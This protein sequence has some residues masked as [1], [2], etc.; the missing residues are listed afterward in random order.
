MCM[1]IC[2]YMLHIRV[3]CTCTRTIYIIG[4]WLHVSSEAFIRRPLW[5]AQS[6]NANST[7]YTHTHTCIHPAPVKRKTS[8]RGRQESGWVYRMP[9]A[10]YPYT[11]PYPYPLPLLRYPVPLTRS[12]VWS[13]SRIKCGCLYKT[14][15]HVDTMGYRFFPFSLCTSLLLPSFIYFFLLFFFFSF[16]FCFM[17][18]HNAVSF[19]L[20]HS[21]SRI[22]IFS[23]SHI[24]VCMNTYMY[25]YMYVCT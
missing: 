25:I 18:I 3:T 23:Y 8:S 19:Y 24:H 22:L 13:T 16:C 17:L 7:E 10:I 14:C 1:Y 20:P 6:P 9:H 2:M 4:T 15:M 11:Y 5:Q 12:T 21:Y